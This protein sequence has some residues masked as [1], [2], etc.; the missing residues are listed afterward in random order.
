MRAHGGLAPMGPT[1]RPFRPILCSGPLQARSGRHM[2]VAAHDSP[3]PANTH[4][5]AARDLSEQIITRSEVIMGRR[6]SVHSY[7]VTLAVLTLLARSPALH[8]QAATLTG[9]V[10]SES[11]QVL[12]NANTFITELNISVGT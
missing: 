10:T 2:I 8:A 4:P 3:R 12:E 7:G 1:L 9:V 5:Q 6:L 11:G